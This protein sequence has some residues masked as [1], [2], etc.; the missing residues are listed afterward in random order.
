MY[1]VIVVGTDG[2]E[3]A[4]EAVERAFGLAQNYDAELHAITVVNTARYGEPALSSYELVLNELEDR[5]N[6]QLKE[7]RDSGSE[8]NIQVVTK[9]FHGNPS[10]EII[11]YA[12]ESDADLIVLGSHGH[13]HPRSVIGS[14]A[15][16]VLHGTSREVLIV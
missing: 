13:T 16:R 3:K 1:E 12:Q 8:R 5:G 11:E 14:T 15:D 10:Q 2:S 4:Q 6:R 9:C 7:I